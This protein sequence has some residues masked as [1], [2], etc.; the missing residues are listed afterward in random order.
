[1]RDVN[2]K[3][4]QAYTTLANLELRK[5]NVSHRETSEMITFCTKLNVGYKNI[6]I[7]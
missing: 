5:N 7:N 6:N 4:G 3:H 2:I 1:M